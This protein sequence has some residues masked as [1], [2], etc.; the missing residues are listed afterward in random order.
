L[1]LQIDHRYLSSGFAYYWLPDALEAIKAKGCCNVQQL[2][3]V[4]EWLNKLSNA[5][6][7]IADRI[8]RF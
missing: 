6:K 2:A 1:V 4:R 7:E 5:N 8:V 3:A